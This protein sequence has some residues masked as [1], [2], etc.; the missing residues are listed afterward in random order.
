MKLSDFASEYDLAG[1]P[2]IS[3]S[4]MTNALLD[5]QVGAIAPESRVE[6]ALA[7]MLGGA[8]YLYYFAKRAHPRLVTMATERG[9]LSSA[10]EVVDTSLVKQAVIGISSTI[11]LTTGRT[12]SLP[13]ALDALEAELATRMTNTVDPE[14]Q[15]AVEL[16]QH[17]RAA[18]NAETVTSLKYVRHLRNKW[19]GHS[20]LDRS[21]D[22][23]AEANTTLHFALLED[24]L[25][26]MVNAF[27]DLGTLAPMSRELRDIEARGHAGEVRADGTEV[28]R[29]TI[30][31][32][33]ATPM[34][35]AMREVAQKA[36]DA[37]LDRLA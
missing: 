36:A 13:H 5:A 32:S 14:T 9:L 17:I 11:D 35:L 26:R 19:A 37:F 22:S 27:Q 29:M 2:A 33:G 10:I 28:V 7:N 30:S 6:L 18:T 1:V 25:A 31:W 12:S 16:I 24:A 20:S 21:V 34:A 8:V 3:G 23:W 15:A 4:P